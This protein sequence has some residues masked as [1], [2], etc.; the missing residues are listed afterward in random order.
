MKPYQHLSMYERRVIQKMFWRGE[1]KADIARILNRE[2]STIG[3]KISRNLSPDRF[4]R[5]VFAQK[6]YYEA[7]YKLK[8]VALKN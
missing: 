1:K 8:P 5:S 4:Y 3:R 6:R 2:R 7:F